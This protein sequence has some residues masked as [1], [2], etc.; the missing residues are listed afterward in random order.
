MQGGAHSPVGRPREKAAERC[1]GT[2]VPTASSPSL[3]RCDRAKQGKFP[4]PSVRNLGLL[5]IPEFP[6]KVQPWQLA[7]VTERQWRSLG[8]TPPN[9]QSIP[10]LDWC[11]PHPP[12]GGRLGFIPGRASRTPI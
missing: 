1:G 8:L 10:E 11:S 12:R 4:L 3:A 9:P 2:T 5:P 6:I 7:V